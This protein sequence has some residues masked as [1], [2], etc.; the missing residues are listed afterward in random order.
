MK[1]RRRKFF[2]DKKFQFKFVFFISIIL[3]ILYLIYPIIIYFLFHKT[4]TYFSFAQ[5]KE[6]LQDVLLYL[7]SIH[8]IIMLIEIILLVF[9]SHKVSGP[10][11]K[12][13]SYFK[14]IIDG[15][16]LIKISF[17]KK[18]FLKDLEKDINEAMYVLNL[19]HYDHID[20]LKKVQKEITS[21]QRCLGDQYQDKIKI[22]DN[23]F[24]EI[25]SK[26]EKL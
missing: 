21:L 1:N 25:L 13:R 4:L 24:E 20:E 3:S 15:K 17:R 10:L 6:L 16:D 23:H 9:V 11:H 7:V 22:I 2:V 8:S 14:N 5:K 26:M 19:K 12:L 18:D